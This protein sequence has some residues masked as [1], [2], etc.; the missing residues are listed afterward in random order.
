MCTLSTAPPL[1]RGAVLQI[2]VPLR[3]SCGSTVA[4]AVFQDGALV[5]IEI[6]AEHHGAK[7]RSVLTLTDICDTLRKAE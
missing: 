7:H 3:C 1:P 4:V 6:Q 5:A 2:R